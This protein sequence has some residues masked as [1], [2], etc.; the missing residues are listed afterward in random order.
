MAKGHITKVYSIKGV[1]LKNLSGFSPI[2]FSLNGLFCIQ[3]NLVRGNQDKI[4]SPPPLIE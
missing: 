3:L 2:G 4:L 1:G